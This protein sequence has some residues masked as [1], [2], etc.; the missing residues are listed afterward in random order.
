MLCTDQLFIASYSGT[1]SLPAYRA[2]FV[3][4]QNFALLA[5]ALG[6]ASTV[7]VSHL[8]QEGDLAG[9]HRILRRNLGFCWLVMLSSSAFLIV[10]GRQVFDVWLGPGN[11][12]GLPILG[13]FLATEI[14]S[15]QSYVISLASRA[16]EDEAFALACL[17]SGILK[18]IL[19]YF[20]IRAFGLLG[21]PAPPLW[22]C[23]SPASGTW[24]TAACGG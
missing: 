12:I 20:F 23:C 16:T 6:A 10:F 3:L 14:I 1:S 19:S 8:W 17:A 13:V 22:P 5:N 9:V 24:S 2:A 11:F 15:T 7:F 21:W 18:L 4:T